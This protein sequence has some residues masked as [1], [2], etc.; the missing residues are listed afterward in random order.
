MNNSYI[1]LG[2]SR[3]DETAETIFMTL[4]LLI[5]LKLVALSAE[6]KNI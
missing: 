5:Y 1:I 2:S 4:Y 6:K 3:N